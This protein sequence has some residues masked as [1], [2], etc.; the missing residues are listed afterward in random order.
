MKNIYKIQWRGISFKKVFGLCLSI[1]TILAINSIQIPAVFAADATNIVGNWHLDE[2]RGKV[3]QDSSG[4]FNAGNLKA[5]TGGKLPTWIARKFDTAALQIA[6][7]GSVEIPDSPIL[8]PANITLEAWVKRA[9]GAASSEYVISK[10]ADACRFASYAFYTGSSKGLIFYISDGKT[11]IESPDAGTK[12]WDNE[13]HHI[14][15]TYDRK[16]VKLY[17]DGKQIG[18]TPTALTIGYGLPT[19]DKFY[20]GGYGTNCVPKFRGDI[21]EV[22]VWNQPL[23]DSEITARAIKTLPN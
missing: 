9:P 2:G 13:W 1:V 6:G 21:D 5:D 14:A 11:Y 22:R 15:G 8:E 10:G 12:I 7:Q 18:A 16:M 17:V 4:N 3:A 20:I 23:T 19:N